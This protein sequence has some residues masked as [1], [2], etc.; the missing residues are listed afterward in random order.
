MG[1]AVGGPV[2]CSHGGPIRRGGGGVGYPRGCL[3]L[4]PRP[5]KDAYAGSSEVT[6]VTICTPSLTT[7]DERAYAR[8]VKA[9]GRK[10]VGKG[11]GGRR[12][13]MA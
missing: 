8:P 3:L 4:R 5:D 7:A 6:R 11:E 1:V 9:N 10:D 13:R 2:F 12:W